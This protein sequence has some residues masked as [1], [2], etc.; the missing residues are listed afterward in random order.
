MQERR[1]QH[2][3]LYHKDKPYSKSFENQASMQ[4]IMTTWIDTL[5][6]GVTKNIILQRLEV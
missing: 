1:W 3:H 4:Y 6:H 2:N 5:L